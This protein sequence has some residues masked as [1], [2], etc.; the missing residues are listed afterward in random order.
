M[1]S[2]TM[3]SACLEGLR[4]STVRKSLPSSA[5]RFLFIFSYIE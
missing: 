5:H 3:R 4:N 1:T 2:E